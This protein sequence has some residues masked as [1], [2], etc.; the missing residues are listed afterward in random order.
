[1]ENDVLLLEFYSLAEA[2]NT[3]DNYEL[4]DSFYEK[5]LELDSQT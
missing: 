5:A 3:L 2:H 1:M 4:S